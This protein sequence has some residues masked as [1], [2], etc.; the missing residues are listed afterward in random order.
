M[1]RTNSTKTLDKEKFLGKLLDGWWQWRLISK[2]NISYEHIF[3]S[4]PLNTFDGKQS[5]IFEPPTTVIHLAT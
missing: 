4:G 2:K 3:Y 1:K 5:N